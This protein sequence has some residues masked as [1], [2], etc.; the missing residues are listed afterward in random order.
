MS[1]HQIVG[2]LVAAAVF[3]G[4]GCSPGVSREEKA[5]LREGA[6]VEVFR[7]APEPSQ[8]PTDGLKIGRYSVLAQGKDQGPDFAARLAEALSGHPKLLKKCGIQPGVAFRIWRGEQC[9][10][11][12]VCFKCDVLAVHKGTGDWDW[13]SDMLRD[14]SA[15][16]ARLLV[17]CKEA[18]PD[19]PVIQGLQDLR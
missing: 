2:S 14:F 17:L 15:G 1:M 13:T 19:D 6:R 8:G 3:V 10:E 5:I 9:V 4:A 12:L 7:V 16:R 18:L 11:V